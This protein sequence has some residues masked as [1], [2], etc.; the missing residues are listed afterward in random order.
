MAEMFYI[1]RIF[2]LYML[3]CIRSNLCLP[4][5]LTLLRSKQEN[6]L[7]FSRFTN[8]APFYSITKGNINIKKI[9]LKLKKLKVYKHFGYRKRKI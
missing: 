6:K 7:V 9:V 8:K 5:K 4:V 3:I 2:M 1:T